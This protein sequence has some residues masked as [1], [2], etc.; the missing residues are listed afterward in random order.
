MIIYG[1]GASGQE[2]ANSLVVANDAWP[3]AFID[4]DASLHGQSIAGIK[5]Y[6]SSY[7]SNLASSFSVDEILLALPNEG[8]RRRSE[9]VASWLGRD[10][11]SEHCQATLTSY[12]GGSM[13]QKSEIYQLMKFLVV[14]LLT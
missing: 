7:I 12:R 1:A 13:S 10:C 14:L 11:Q 4:D 9:I 2:L 3:V 8:R 6:P 5:V